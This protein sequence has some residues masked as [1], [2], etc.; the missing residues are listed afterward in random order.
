MCRHPPASATVAGQLQCQQTRQWR[1]GLWQW[2]AGRNPKQ[3]QMTKAQNSK[4]NGQKDRALVPQII[5][6]DF[7]KS[8]HLDGKVKSSYASPDSVGIEE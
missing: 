3:I 1:A 4:Q 5:F 7:V 2:R 6:D 8:H